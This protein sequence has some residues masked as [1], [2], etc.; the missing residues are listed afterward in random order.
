MKILRKKAYASSR[1]S[2]EEVCLQLFEARVILAQ[3]PNTRLHRLPLTHGNHEI[4]AFAPYVREV[5]AGIITSLDACL[6]TP[7]RYLF[8]A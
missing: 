4:R 8:A 3:L 6:S 1:S 5:I 7:N 2:E